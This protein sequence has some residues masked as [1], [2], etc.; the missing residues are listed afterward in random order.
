MLADSK[1][2][3]VLADEWALVR[4]GLASL[5][6]ADPAFHVVAQCEDGEAALETIRQM[7]PDLAAIDLD[8]P[9]LHALEVVR[10]VRDAGFNTRVA[11]LTIRR[12]RKSLAEALR[13][14]ASAFVLKSDTARHV[15]SAFHQLLSGGVYISPGFEVIHAPLGTR[16]QPEPTD[17]VDKLSTREYQVFTLLVDGCRAKEIAY[18]LE[19]S[20]KTVDT[21][22]ASLMRKLDVGDLAA[23]VKLAIRRNL[24]CA[25]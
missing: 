16:R 10:R 23:L 9:K 5:C 4:E 25:G 3:I 6:E 17:P 8:I 15:L 13:A 11:I 24:T 22:R 1:H 7:Q 20:P 2:T 19:L 21:Y 14:G 18:R 12:D